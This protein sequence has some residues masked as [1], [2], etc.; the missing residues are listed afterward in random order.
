MPASAS[1]L[2]PVLGHKPPSSIN[3][4]TNT[5]AVMV[6]HPITEVVMW[7]ILVT[8]LRSQVDIHIRGVHHLISP[9]VCG[10]GI[11]YLTLTHGS[12]RR[13]PSI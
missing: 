3:E 12:S 2:R 11:K 6:P 10:I 8:T 1:G 9:A 7:T 4:T 13:R 5:V